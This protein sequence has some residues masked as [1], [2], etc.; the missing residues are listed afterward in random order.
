ML[1]SNFRTILPGD[2][3]TTMKNST[4]SDSSKNKNST[5]ETTGSNSNA[6]PATLDKRSESAGPIAKKRRVP[7]SITQNACVNC[8]KARAKVS[9]SNILRL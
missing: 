4:S 7:A 8:K 9:D 5:P 6:T 1:G 2:M 3:D